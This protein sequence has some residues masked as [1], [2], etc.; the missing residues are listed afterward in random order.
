MYGKDIVS[1]AQQKLK[2]A[3]LNRCRLKQSLSTQRDLQKCALLLARLGVVFY[4][5]ATWEFEGSPWAT[6]IRGPTTGS[7]VMTRQQLGLV[8]TGL[9][10]SLQNESYWTQVIALYQTEPKLAFYESGKWLQGWMWSGTRFVS[11][12][13]A[14]AGSLSWKCLFPGI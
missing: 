1:Q 7:M 2:L 8:E 12:R 13:V 10:A 4:N 11:V 9:G 14:P 6:A 3:A 5:P